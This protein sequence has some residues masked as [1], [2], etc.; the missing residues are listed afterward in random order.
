MGKIH[1]QKLHSGRE[2]YLL[3]AGLLQKLAALRRDELLTLPSIGL[4]TRLHRV[5]KQ[6]LVV[7]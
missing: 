7:F 4:E 3:H 6:L 2:T 5:F 1:E